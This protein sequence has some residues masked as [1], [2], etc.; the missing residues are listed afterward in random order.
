M[1]ITL[2]DR[3]IE[4]LDDLAFFFHNFL[5]DVIYQSEK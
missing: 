4:Y 5:Q 2:D 3:R 1:F